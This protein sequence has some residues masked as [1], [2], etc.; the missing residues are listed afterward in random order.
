MAREELSNLYSCC[1]EQMQC[2]RASDES[3][4]ELTVLQ[5]FVG[6]QLIHVGRLEKLRK[7]SAHFLVNSFAAM[8]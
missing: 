4:E 6:G 1:G 3:K 5:D 2:H 7:G 8:G